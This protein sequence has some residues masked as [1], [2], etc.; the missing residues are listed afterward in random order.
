MKAFELQVQ[1]IVE[2]GCGR[3]LVP[4]GDSVI[5]EAESQ[6]KAQQK[7]AIEKLKERHNTTGSYH[8]F[9]VTQADKGISYV[10][11]FMPYQWFILEGVTTWH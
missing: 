4:V 3:K 1:R 7:A 10:N 11:Q 5:V 6:C 8:R 2:K 9:L